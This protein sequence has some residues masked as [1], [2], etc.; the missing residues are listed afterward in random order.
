ML[1]AR[2]TV[3][4]RWRMCR[5][6]V[7]IKLSSLDATVPDLGAARHLT[8]VSRLLCEGHLNKHIRRKPGPFRRAF[9]GQRLFL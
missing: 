1:P 5:I 6:L 8:H 2:R 4:R 3:W 7:G 9:L